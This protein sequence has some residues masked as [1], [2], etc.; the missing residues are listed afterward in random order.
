MLIR[1]RLNYL[2]HTYRDMTL[3]LHYTG[4]LL[5]R[6]RHMFNQF[7]YDMLHNVLLPALYQHMRVFRA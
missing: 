3:G 5:M 1:Q 7:R 6:P 2:R 4:N